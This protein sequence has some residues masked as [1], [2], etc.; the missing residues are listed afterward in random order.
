MKYYDLYIIKAAPSKELI[1]AKAIRKKF[2]WVQLI[3]ALDISRG[4]STKFKVAEYVSEEEFPKQENKWIEAGAVTEKIE[5]EEHED[6]GCCS[7]YSQIDEDAKFERWYKDQNFD[8]PTG[9]DPRFVKEVARK[10]WDYG[11]YYPMS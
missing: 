9:T 6:W 10:A 4:K 5:V 7:L 1:L 8:I 3:H 2:N 11:Q